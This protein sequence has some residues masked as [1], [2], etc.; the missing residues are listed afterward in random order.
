MVARNQ[1]KMDEKVAE[2]K[3]KFPE[4]KY[5]TVLADFSKMHTIKEYKDIIGEKVKNLD[6]AMVFLNA[7][8]AQMGCFADIDE[9][10][11]EDQ[12]TVNAMHPMYLTKALLPQLLARGKKSAIVTTSSVMG[13][14]PMGGFLTYSATKSLA[15][16][17]AIGLSYEL[18]G[19]VD[20]MAWEAGEIATKLS[21]RKPGLNVLTVD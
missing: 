9:A 1:A 20:V 11:V 16:F 21:K 17:I 10:H 7:G 5:V 14:R 18:E 19:K 13:Q 12:M 15:S 3:K 2:V 4:R 8:I 6:I